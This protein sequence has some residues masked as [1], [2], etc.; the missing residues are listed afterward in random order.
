MPK[1]PQFVHV[2][3]VPTM[4]SQLGPRLSNGA[5]QLTGRLVPY[6]E[7]ADVLD[8]LEGDDM[9]L[10]REGF[11]PGA[12]SLQVNAEAKNTR[13]RIGLI[14]RHDGGLGYLGPFIALREAPDGLYGDV[15]I[16]PTKGDDVAALL[17]DGVDELSIEFR[18][19]RSG[20]HTV[21]DNEGVRWRTRAHLDAVALE[22]KGAYRSAQVMAYRAEVDELEA[23]AAKLAAEAG[24]KTSE[25][26]KL[27]AEAAEALK[28]RERWDAMTARLDVEL[29]RQRHLLHDYGITQTDRGYRREKGNV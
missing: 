26:E 14:H 20:D 22:P 11:R 12:F 9:D 19:P 18:L 5:R 2:R 21:V 29:E 16:L 8:I 13:T 7:A 6:N 25:E 27:E 23:E 3:A 15:R 24:Q 4:I 1:P 28:V 17:E 10:Y